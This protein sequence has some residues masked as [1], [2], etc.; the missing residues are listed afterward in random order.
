MGNAED[1]RNLG[2]DMASSYTDRT[3]RVATLAKETATMLKGFQKEN[4]EREEMVGDLL[5]NF[6]EEEEKMAEELKSTLSKNEAD[7]VKE[8]QAEIKVRIDAVGGLL[9]GFHTTHKEMSASLKKAL[10]DNETKRLKDQAEIKERVKDVKGLLDGFQ[11]E[12]DKLASAWQ[13]LVSLMEKTR[14]GKAAAKPK[15]APKKVKKEEKIE[16]EEE[17]GGEEGEI[18][19]ILENYPD[20]AT[21]SEIADEMDVHFATLIRPMGRLVDDD[22]VE[23]VDNRY[24]LT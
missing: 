10:A 16:E 7:R 4:E 9:K 22:K 18:V 8:A 1:I 15:E 13:N 14:T 11:K 17:L 3:K 19:S 5:S 6:H 23:K 20:G 21:L 2:E 12:R 24:L